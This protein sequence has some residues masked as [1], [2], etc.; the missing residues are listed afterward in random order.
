MVVR[1]CNGDVL[2]SLSA[3]RRGGSSSYMAKGYALG[4]A[5][6]LCLELGFEDVIFEGNAKELIDVM[7]DEVEDES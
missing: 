5:T 7:L 3:A 2:A 4:R 6:M 1:D